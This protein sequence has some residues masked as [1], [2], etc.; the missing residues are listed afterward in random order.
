MPW[1]YYVLLLPFWVSFVYIPVA[2]GAILCL[3]VVR[4][5]SRPPPGHPRRRRG[6]GGGRRGLDGGGSCDASPGDLLTPG[7]FREISGQGSISDYRLLPGWWLTTGLV[8]AAN[9][10]PDE[11]V[12]FLALIISSALFFRL[13]SLWTATEIGP[14]AYHLTCAAVFLAVL[15]RRCGWS[16][17]S[18]PAAGDHSGAAAAAWYG[19]VRRAVF[20]PRARR[21]RRGR[22]GADGGG[23]AAH[24]AWRF[25]LGWWAGRASIARP[26][27]GSTARSCGGNGAPAPASTKPSALLGWSP[28]TMR[29]MTVKDFRLFRRDPLQ[30]S[31]V[32]IFGGADRGLFLQRPQLH[33]RPLGEGLGNMV[34]FLNLAVVG[35][36]LSTFTTRF[37]YPMI[38]LEGR[39]FWILGLLGVRREAVLEQ[40]LVRDVGDRSLLRPG[41]LEP[42]C[43]HVVRND[44]EVVLLHQLLC[45]VLCFGLAGIAVGFAPGFRTPARTRPRGWRPGSAGR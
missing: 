29:L 32:L 15:C 14:L 42:S 24:G 28:R 12:L 10:V 31:Q 44:P 40:V 27:A 41:V 2:I 26:S 25:V 20:R 8:D 19:S 11:S 38:S 30:W 1:Y 22:L 23:A 36:L 35:L 17:P 37:I 9:G 21:R 7:W 39:R 6:R 3:L 43:L 16:A 33:L 13:V 4:Q 34:S 5:F 18:A 45:V